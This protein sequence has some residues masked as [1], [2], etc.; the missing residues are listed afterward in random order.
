MVEKWRRIFRPE[1]SLFLGVLFVGLLGFIRPYQEDLAH[2]IG[3]PTMG[4]GRVL[5]GAHFEI[6]KEFLGK[7]TIFL[8]GSVTPPISGDIK[9]SLTG[10]EQLDYELS[11]RNPPGVP[12]INGNHPWYRF[13]GDMI[14]GT[15]PG[16]DMVIVATIKPPESPGEY[17]M[18][19]SSPATGQVYL[20]VPVSFTLPGQESHAE[21]EAE[22]A[23]G[24]WGGSQE[25]DEQTTPIGGPSA[26]PGGADDQ[27]PDDD[28]LEPCH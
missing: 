13:D 9:V 19:L 24:T 5:H 12:L 20:N 7:Y 22:P 4:G 17:A 14:K 8:T 21:T 6:G 23:T 10:P 1:A 15:Q 28:A 3:I 18:I 16:D 11:S 2:V 27:A 26:A 25:G